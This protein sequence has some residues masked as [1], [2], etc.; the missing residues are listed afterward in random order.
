[1]Q[2]F[3]SS[4]A[5]AAL[6]RGLKRLRQDVSRVVLCLAQLPN[7]RQSQLG[8][9]PSA[10]TQ[11]QAVVNQLSLAALLAQSVLDNHEAAEQ[12][13]E[14]QDGHQ[15]L[16]TA[17]DQLQQAV[18]P[19]VKAARSAIKAAHSSCSVTVN[20]AQD[21]LLTVAELWKPVRCCSSTD[22]QPKLR[23]LSPYLL[24]LWLLLLLMGL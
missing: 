11:L 8:N 13:P 22:W 19:A 5:I 24:L 14:Q 12:H 23:L 4:D 21:V 17:L 20:E 2:S 6:S 18:R 3:T 10:P 1:M 7:T 15:T 9:E 16:H